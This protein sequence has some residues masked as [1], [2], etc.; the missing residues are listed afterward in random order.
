MKF[1]GYDDYVYI[2]GDQLNMTVFFSY[3]VKSY[4]PM[5][6]FTIA[7]TGQLIFYKAPE[8]HGHV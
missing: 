5:Y 8:K 7:L 6:V 3:L 4:L 2:Q 1:F